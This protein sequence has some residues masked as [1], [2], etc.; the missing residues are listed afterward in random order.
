MIQSGAIAYGLATLAKDGSVLDTWYPAPQLAEGVAEN[1]SHVLSEADVRTHLG[2]SFIKALG[3]CELRGVN[4]V[5]VKTSIATLAEPPKDTHDVFLRLHLL[6]HRLIKPHQAN[7]TGI[8][9]LLA[10]VAWTSMGPCPLDQL[11][12]ARLRARAARVVFDVKA[13]LLYT[14][15]SPRD[16]AASRMPSSA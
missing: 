15:P 13:C 9:G 14:S 6:S 8:F 7:V 3:T 11:Q 12:E 2:E 1:G 16:Y 10:N 4:V 5:A